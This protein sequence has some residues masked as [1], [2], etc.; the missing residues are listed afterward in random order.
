[1]PSDYE[2]ITRYNEEQLGKDTASRK[3][4]INMYSDFSHFIFEILQNADDYEATEITFNL[5][6]EELI[7]EHNGIPFTEENVKAISYFGK[8]T[9]REDLVKTG[10][11]GLGF[12]SVFAFTATPSIHSGD[13]NFKIYG[14]Y[15]LKALTRPAD[16]ETGRTRIY[17]PFNHVEE[18]PDFV[19]IL[20]AKETAFNRISHRLKKLDLTTLLFTRNILEIQWT[21]LDEKGHCEEGHY[22]RVDKEKNNINENIQTRQTEITDGDLLQTYFVFSRPVRW[23]GKEYRPVEIAYFLDDADGAKKIHS[24]KKPLSVLFP[25]TKETCMGFLIN[26]PFRTPPHSGMCQ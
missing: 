5:T 7:I 15:R 12:K 10:H 24:I 11:F 17:L 22:L 9:S 25:T 18:E 6:P 16:L 20:V 21:I 2:A 14:L 13:E 23:N 8:S 1:M 4:Q 3:S 19:D 26:G